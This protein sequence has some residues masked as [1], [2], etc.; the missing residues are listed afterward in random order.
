ML[1][2]NWFGLSVSL[3][4][5]RKLTVHFFVC[6]FE[7]MY[8]FVYIILNTNMCWP[9]SNSFEWIRLYTFFN[10]S[11]RVHSLYHFHAKI[12]NWLFVLDFHI[13]CLWM[14]HMKNQYKSCILLSLCVKSDSAKK[15]SRNWS[16][17]K[18]LSSFIS[19]HFT[20][21][22]FVVKQRIAYEILHTNDNIYY[23]I[24]NEN[25]LSL[26]CL[27]VMFWCLCVCE[28][29]NDLFSSRPIFHK[30]YWWNCHYSYTTIYT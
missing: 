14:A 7:F 2:I 30:I 24:W 17:H 27:W 10:S 9:P 12:L 13:C 19:F 20:T 3:T 22:Y 5:K 23:L 21:V 29:V 28:C 18:R 8:A 26:E 6:A 25:L 1:R 15:N 16:T 11:L 4:Q